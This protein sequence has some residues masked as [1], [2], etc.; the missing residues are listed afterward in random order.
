VAATPP[1]KDP[2]LVGLAAAVDRSALA[3]DTASHL[4]VR[5]RVSA[6]QA[7]GLAR[8]PLSLVLVVDTSGSMV[9]DPIADARTAAL[10][11]VEALAPGDRIAIVTFDSRAEVLVA[12]TL[13]DAK[14]GKAAIRA[15][16][17]RMQARGTTDMAAGL[18]TAL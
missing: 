17:E 9:G 5:L 18:Q 10:A 11:M 6:E 8:P 3:A 4:T 14:T 15:A 16:I 12:P 2:Q 1:A 7:K 13:I